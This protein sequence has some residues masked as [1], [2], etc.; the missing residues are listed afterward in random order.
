MDRRPAQ[1]GE[2]VRIV[3]RAGF[4]PPELAGM[5]R[6]LRAVAGPPALIAAVQGLQR[7]FALAVLAVPPERAFEVRPLPGFPYPTGEARPDTAKRAVRAG[8]RE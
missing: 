7:R 3:L 6:E 5:E 8:H 1:P 2:T 4:K